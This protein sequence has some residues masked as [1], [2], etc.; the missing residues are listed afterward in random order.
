M[1]RKKTLDQIIAEK[2]KELRELR[3]RKRKEA[4]PF[5]LTSKETYGLKALLR[6]RHL[7]KDFWKIKEQAEALREHPKLIEIPVNDGSVFKLVEVVK[8]WYREYDAIVLLSDG[9]FIQAGSPHF[10]PAPL[11]WTSTKVEELNLETSYRGAPQEFLT[12]DFQGRFTSTFVKSM[13]SAAPIPQRIAEELKRFWQKRANDFLTEI[14]LQ[15]GNRFL[16][17]AQENIESLK[18][19]RLLVQGENPLDYPLRSLYVKN[20]YP[21][22]VVPGYYRDLFQKRKDRTFKTALLAAVEWFTSQINFLEEDPETSPCF[23]IPLKEVVLN[24]LMH[25]KLSE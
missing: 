9:R 5:A 12:P 18:W 1:A 8:Y 3:A 17:G 4:S 13:K 6:S 24:F 16:A 11:A 14:N 19:I 7:E 10:S 2:E 22:E 23:E 20:P 15:E 21:S 25:E